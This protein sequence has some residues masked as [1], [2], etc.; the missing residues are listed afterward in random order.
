MAFLSNTELQ[1]M[2][3]KMVS[4]PSELKANFKSRS[5]EYHERSETH[6]L[7][8]KYENE[9]WEVYDVLKTK[10]KLRKNKTVAQ[11][12]EDDVWCQMYSLGFDQLNWDETLELPFG[13][14]THE[15]KQIDVLAIKDDI[16]LIIECKSAEKPRKYHAKDEFEL[17]G[18]RLDGFRKAI[19]QYCGRKMRVK[20]V[21]ATRNLR[22][23]ADSVDMERFVK[24][25]SYL[26]NE[27]SFRYV[28]SLINKYKSASGYQFLGLL[29][30]NEII[31]DKKIEIP[32]LEGEMGGQTYYMFSIEPG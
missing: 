20:Y 30:K 16:A 14:E 4:D 3:Q 12:L 7:V 23:D 13:K 24:T 6:N 18:L 25:R 2:T 8:E 26:H 28:K 21:L 5:K 22:V 11:K 10:T 15:K 17:L 32:A 27:G 1:K 19:I 9:G 31:N 29:F